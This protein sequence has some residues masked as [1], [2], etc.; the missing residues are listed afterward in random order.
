MKG[1]AT[2]AGEGLGGP[3]G[4]AAGSAAGAAAGAAAAAAAAAFEASSA[5]HRSSKETNCE[6]CSDASVGGE[7]AEL[8]GGSFAA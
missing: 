1:A 3:M 4:A 6:N 2:A 5:R 8:W 7:A